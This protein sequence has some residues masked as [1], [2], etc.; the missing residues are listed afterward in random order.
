MEGFTVNQ[1]YGVSNPRG[2][3]NYHIS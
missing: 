3:T 2:G 1:G